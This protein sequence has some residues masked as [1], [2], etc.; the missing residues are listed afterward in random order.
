MESV[1]YCIPGVVGLLLAAGWHL[2]AMDWLS[3]DEP[4]PTPCNLQEL[5][6]YTVVA[7]GA[8]LLV[9]AVAALALC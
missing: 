1:L 9:V 4:S 3:S 6:C 5:L 2:A 7:L 8:V